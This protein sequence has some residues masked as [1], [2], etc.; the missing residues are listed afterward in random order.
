MKVNFVVFSCLLHVSSSLKSAVV[1]GSGPV[2]LASALVLAKRHGYEVTVLEAAERI[3]VYDPSKGYPF[4]IKPRGQ[5]VS[6]PKS[7]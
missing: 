3:D 4:L 1:I 6:C 5:K 7:K 2:G